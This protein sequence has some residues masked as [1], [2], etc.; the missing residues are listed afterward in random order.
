[1]QRLIQSE[2]KTFNKQVNS[3]KGYWGRGNVVSDTQYSSYVRGFHTTTCNGHSFEKGELMTR[4]LEKF[5]HLLK[6]FGR[7]RVAK[8]LT[9]MPEGILYVFFHNGRNGRFVHGWMLTDSTHQ[10]VEDQVMSGRNQGWSVLKEMRKA[11]CTKN[12][13]ETLKALLDAQNRQAEQAA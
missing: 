5:N 7:Q 2:H 9:H 10:F 13:H 3:L 8:H 6:Q 11:I 4:D 1:M 12:A